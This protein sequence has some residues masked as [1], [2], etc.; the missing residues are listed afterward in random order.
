MEQLKKSINPSR[1]MQIGMGFWASKVVLSA[2]DMQ[3]FTYLSRGT[4][5]ARQIQ[6][7]FELHPRGL[8]D[9]LDALVAL[10]FLTRVGFKEDAL[11]GNAE[12]VA[13]FLDKKKPSYIGGMLEM[14]NRRLFAF[15]N[16]LEEGLKTGQPQNETKGG[17]PSVFEAI[18]ASEAKTR[19]FLKAMGSLQMGNFMAFAKAFDFSRYS[20]LCDIGGARGD[21]SVQVALNH[22]HMRCIT[23]DLAPASKIAAENLRQMGLDERVEARTGDFFTDAFPKADVI[24]MGNVLHD[25]GLE[26][27]K[28]LIRKA[29]EALPIGG[30]LVVLE[31][32][33]DD[34]RKKNVF[35][36]LMSLNM[37]I[38]TEA[39]FDF[40][41]QDFDKWAKGCG[42]KATT[43]MPLTGPSSAVIAL[44]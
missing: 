27:K 28:K 36:L 5:S 41:A 34:A 8:Y 13:V 22:K 18:Y 7:R 31:N 14:C 39:G 44:K 25:W 17:G 38:E 30:S 19:D 37:L 6:D 35:G 40:S 32:I 21:L 3:L 4:R 15:W 10:G 20:S 33:I 24:T 1:I 16:K 12:D 26:D 29:Y 11:Y 43:R 23:F 42:F 2:V 9:F